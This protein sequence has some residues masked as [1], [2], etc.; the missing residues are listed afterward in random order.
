MDGLL[1]VMGDCGL[2]GIFL[3]RNELFWVIVGN[4]FV[5]IGCLGSLWDFMCG[6]GLSLVVWIVL[7][8]LLVVVGCSTVQ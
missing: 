8:G 1:I 6:I 4:F 7:G 2:L 3:C 5:V